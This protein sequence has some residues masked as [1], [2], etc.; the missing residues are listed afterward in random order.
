MIA[1]ARTFQ[2]ELIKAKNTFALWLTIAGA[3]FIPVLFL[4]AYIAKWEKFIP[5]DGQNPWN[6]LFTNAF[7]GVSFFFVPMFVIL[8]NCLIFNIEHKSNTWKH[9]FTQ[10]ISKA[11]VFLNKFLI[12]N[13]LTM[14]CYGFFLLILFC[15][16]IILGIWK[17]E[18]GFLS[19]TPDFSKI[20]A[21][22][23]KSYISVL[24][25]IAIHFWLGFRVK[26]VILP[27]GIGLA[28]V[29]TAGIIA[30]RWK[31]DIYFPYGFPGYCVYKPALNNEFLANYHVYSLI[32]FVLI[33]L[34]ALIDFT[35]NY[36][37]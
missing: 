4:I 15:F 5:K 33:M 1:F 30:G 21:F 8:L 19:A 14:L 26:N 35:R 23:L 2:T 7:I 31:Y 32:Y 29:V 37:G 6:G 20:V 3:G 17:H 28:G 10:P 25:I 24:A 16:G 34:M 27:I 22:A 11:T 12:I 36:K 9:L 13:S 18:L